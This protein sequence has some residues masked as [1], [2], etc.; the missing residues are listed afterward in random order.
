MTKRFWK[1][2]AAEVAANGH[3]ISLD[4]R[5]VR[6]P[7]RL[8]LVVPSPRL[9]AAIV[10]EWNAVEGAVDPAAMR[11]TGLANASIERVAPATSTF[12]AGIARY[13]ESDL[14]CYRAEAPQPLAER[15]AAAWNSLLA[16]AEGRF[17][18]EFAITTGVMHVAQPPATVAVLSEE[19][20]ALDPFV[21]A[22]LSQVVTLTG[23]LIGGLALLEGAVD[24]DALWTAAHIDEAW[25]AEQWGEDAEAARALAAR[26][27][28]YDAAVSFLSLLADSPQT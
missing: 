23:T 1:A 25:Q 28:D 14:L 2:A 21:L 6:T 3:A 4:G 18:I 24:A 22:P 16:W 7:G 27:A 20:A 10:A 26:R 15:Q 13:A 19:V 8:P 17:G 12:A 11:L 5:P 9:A